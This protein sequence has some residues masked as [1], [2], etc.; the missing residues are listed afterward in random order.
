[1]PKKKSQDGR[2]YCSFRRDAMDILENKKREMDRE[3]IG[4]DHSMSEVVVRMDAERPK[5]RGDRALT[6]ISNFKDVIIPILVPLDT[7]HSKHKERLEHMAVT[8][9][10]IG[11]LIMTAHLDD[12]IMKL[13][14]NRLKELYDDIK[15]KTNGLKNEKLDKFKKK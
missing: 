12:K 1:L 15:E 10:L 14:N 5:T 9:D 13:L 3:S 4:T 2:G 8:I 6:A 7:A 11:D